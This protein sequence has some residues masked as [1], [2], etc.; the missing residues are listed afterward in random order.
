[1]EFWPLVVIC[2]RANVRS[3]VCF[4]KKELTTGSTCNGQASE[5]AANME[6]A[7][8]SEAFQPAKVD[9]MPVDVVVEYSIMPQEYL[10]PV[11]N[12]S[13]K[14]QAESGTR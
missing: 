10:V 4:A 11:W 12:M 1:L 2:L 8:G 5:S 9:P 13:N 3:K 6:V 14:V 7:A